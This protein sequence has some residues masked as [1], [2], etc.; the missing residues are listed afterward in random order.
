MKKVNIS[1]ESLLGTC[2]RERNFQI[3]PKVSQSVAD[4][5]NSCDC[6]QKRG[7]LE[8]GLTACKCGKAPCPLPAVWVEVFFVSETPTIFAKY[9]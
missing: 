7:C 3:H 9:C 8:A 4:S 1:Y 2:T 5:K 6:F